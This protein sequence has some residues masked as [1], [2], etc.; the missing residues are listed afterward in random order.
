MRKFLAG[1]GDFHH[2]P[3]K[4]N[5]VYI[6]IYYTYTYTYNIYKITLPTDFHIQSRRSCTSH[7]SCAKVAILLQELLST[8][9]VTDIYGI[10]FH[11]PVQCL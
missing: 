10:Y 9:C 7:T 5:S 1:G 3:S 11:L 2:C 8:L 6:Y 4:E